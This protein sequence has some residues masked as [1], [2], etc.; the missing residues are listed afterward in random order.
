MFTAKSHFIFFLGSSVRNDYISTW[1]PSNANT[2]CAWI[3][4]EPWIGTVIRLHFDRMWI[5]TNLPEVRSSS[6]GKS[7][8]SVRRDFWEL[9]LLSPLPHESVH[10]LR[11]LPTGALGC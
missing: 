2:A 6:Q 11:G 7:G 4:F 5:R 3:I 8:R 10:G 9:C 1:K